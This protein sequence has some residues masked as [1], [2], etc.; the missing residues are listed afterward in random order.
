MKIV[1][2]NGIVFD[3]T[4]GI[5]GEKMDVFIKDGRIVNKI[6]FGAKVIDV[7]NKLVMPGGFDIHSHIAGGKENAG[8]LFRP[9]DS[10]KKVFSRK[11]EL[12][13]GSGSSVPSIFV[14]GY[15]YA[16]MGYTTVIT[17][18]MPPLF[19]RH[20]HHEL[21]DLPIVDKAAFPVLDGNWFVMD[22]I[23]EGDIGAVRNY[24]AWLLEATKGFAI[25]IV[26]PGGTEAWGWRKEI[27][28]IDEPVPYFDVSPRE[29]IYCL[30]RVCEELDLPHSVHIHCNNLGMP[31]N[32][33]TTLQTIRITGKME[34][35]HRQLLHLTHVQFHSYGGNSWKDFES[36][37]ENIAKYI[38]RYNVTIDTGNIMFGDTTTMTADGPLE[39]HLHTL[40]GM[41]WI[42]KDVEAETAPGVTPI[43]Y[44]PRSAV[45]AV[46]WAIGL[47]LALLVDAEKVMLTTDHP[48]GASFTSYPKIIA[49][50]MS[51][52]YREEEMKKLNTAV[53][54]RA[55][56]GSIDREYDF[57]EV[58]MITRANQAI[59]TGMNDRGHLGE[60]AV[61]DIAVYDINPLNVSSSDYKFIEKAFSRAYLTIKNGQVVVKEG[62]VVS[63][64]SG[65]TYWVKA[66]YE[67]WIERELMAYFAENYSVSMQNFVV[68]NDELRR[69]A[70][71]RAQA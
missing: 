62:K 59:A 2:K 58:A 29:I 41:K 8:R 69:G 57:Q 63:P 19:A 55:V 10:L 13:G 39:Y 3:P 68:R 6:W 33:D 27:A 14:T 34:K 30:I 40:T 49:M 70:Y 22:S 31:G 28:G 17:P 53:E 36:K 12:R 45:N 5:N 48:N 54:S 67:K 18:A 71:V 23:A 9:E 60:G 46:Q 65:R 21:N 35:S 38:N 52:K 66:D 50:L 1:L 16:R 43:V 15:E 61:A 56:L 42:N 25:K 24:V 26:N 7:S 32:Y 4:N 37:S 51:K 20:T 44:S 47:E 64:T 11:N